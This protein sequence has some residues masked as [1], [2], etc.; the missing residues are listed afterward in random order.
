MRNN[1]FSLLQIAFDYSAGSWS[2]AAGGLP[3]GLNRELPN[4]REL[5]GQP[6]WILVEFF[7][8]SE[9]II[10]SNVINLESC[11]FNLA[12]M[13]LHD[14]KNFLFQGCVVGRRVLRSDG[15]RKDQNR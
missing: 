13:L 1:Q 11:R 3:D 8:S 12:R 4:C 10:E 9:P 7:E 15:L 6:G 14:P 2:P 5:L